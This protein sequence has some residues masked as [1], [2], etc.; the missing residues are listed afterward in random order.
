MQP[1]PHHYSTRVSG[2]PDQNL[3]LSLEN[4]LGL[5]V[6]PPALFDGPGDQWTPEELLT[7]S[8]ASCLVL[9]FRAI[10]KVSKFEWLD[11]DVNTVGKLERVE[12]VTKFTEMVTTAKLVI[13]AGGD[14][15]QA[16]KLLHKAEST[17]FISN[18]MNCKID[19]VCEITEAE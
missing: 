6:A 2:K 17:C 8:L 4:G 12:K 16:E 11:I 3:D 5:V 10:C 14:K 9:S 19:L 18:T 1:L 13:P 7:A 15:E